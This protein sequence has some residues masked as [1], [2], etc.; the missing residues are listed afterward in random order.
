MQSKAFDAREFYLVTPLST[1]LL[2]KPIVT[3]LV[4]KFPAFMETEDS[5]SQNPAIFHYERAN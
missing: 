5:C 3:Q 4:T 1:V 2:E